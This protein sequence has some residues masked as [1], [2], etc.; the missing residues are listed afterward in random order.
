MRGVKGERRK[1]G[2]REKGREVKRREKEREDGEKWERG[3]KVKAG[4]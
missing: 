3:K 4:K 1:S 2:L